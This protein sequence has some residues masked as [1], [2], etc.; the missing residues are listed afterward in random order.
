MSDVDPGSERKKGEVIGLVVG[1]VLAAALVAFILQNTRKA[2][3]E[4]LVWEVNAPLWL[5][6]VVAAVAAVAL[7]RIVVFITRRRRR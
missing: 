3:I 4:W 6:I 2:R 5:A 1:A 7:E